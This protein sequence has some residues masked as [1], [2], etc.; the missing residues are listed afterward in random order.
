ML[1][2]QLGAGAGREDSKQ[3]ER[4]FTKYTRLVIDDNQMAQNIS[5]CINQWNPRIALRTQ[6][7]YAFILRKQHL[8]PFRIRTGIALN[9]RLTR[10][11]GKWEFDIVSEILSLP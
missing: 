6:S 1:P 7:H 10:R 2:F 3:R 11:A 5:R 8:Q 9:H 4:L